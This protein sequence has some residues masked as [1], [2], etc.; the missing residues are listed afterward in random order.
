MG[1]SSA[2]HCGLH[3][4]KQ[5]DGHIGLLQKGMT[6]S[7]G[8]L[9]ATAAGF[10]CTGGRLPKPPAPRLKLVISFSAMMRPVCA[11]LNA[12]RHND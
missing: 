7:G 4:C 8:V 1:D 10:R 6:H 3:A 12:V 11:H 2:K 9:R 5:D